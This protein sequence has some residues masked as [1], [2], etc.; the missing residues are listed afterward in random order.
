MG[1]TNMKMRPIHLSILLCLFTLSTGCLVMSN[2]D[3]RRTGK[4]VSQSIF[5]QIKPGT[6]TAAWILATLGEPSTKTKA[7]DSEVWK[8]EYTET[9][10]SGGAVFLIFGGH[11]TKQS[12]GTAYVEIKDGVVSNAWRD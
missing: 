5:E 11:S 3:E 6:T 4:Y 2:S 12:K 8:W 10:E 9:K 1:E 7:N